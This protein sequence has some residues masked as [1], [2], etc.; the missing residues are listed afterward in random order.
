MRGLANY[1]AVLSAIA[2]GQRRP[3]E[4]ALA[5]GLPSGSAVDPYLVRLVE[6]DYV[7]REL[8]VTV[9]P[10]KRAASRLSRYVSAG[11]WCD[12]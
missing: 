4:I 5:A 2:G 7:R 3:A 10:K 9:D 6:M 11:T 12:S 8:S 1:Q